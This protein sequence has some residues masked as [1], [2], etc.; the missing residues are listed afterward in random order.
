MRKD[1]KQS[2][3]SPTK[4]IMLPHMEQHC[5]ENSRVHIHTAH[6]HHKRRRNILLTLQPVEHGGLAQNASLLN[7]R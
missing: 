3:K 4:N 5:H 1:Q 6:E 7:H 2:K